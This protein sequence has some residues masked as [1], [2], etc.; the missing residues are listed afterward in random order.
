MVT[1]GTRPNGVHAGRARMN[2]NNT[3]LCLPKHARF[4]F[5]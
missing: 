3:R 1:D 5:I 4:I 2:F